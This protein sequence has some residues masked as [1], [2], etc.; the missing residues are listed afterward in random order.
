VALDAVEEG[1][2]EQAMVTFD[3][4]FTI[5]LAILLLLAAGAVARGGWALRT[6][7]SGAAAESRPPVASDPAERRAA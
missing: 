6:F 1:A 2:E 5:S 3:G 7:R 4:Q